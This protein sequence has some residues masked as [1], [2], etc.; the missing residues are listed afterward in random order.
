MAIAFSE[1]ASVDV[2]KAMASDPDAITLLPPSVPE[3]IP[4]APNHSP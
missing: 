3:P 4:I 1:S 2:P